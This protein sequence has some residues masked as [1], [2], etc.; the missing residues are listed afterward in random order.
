M[1]LGVYSLEKN[2]Y[3]DEARSVNCKTTMGEITI[4][5]N[6]QPLISV[7]AKGVIK[8]IDEQN[9]EHYIDAE[10]GFLT[11]LE[12]NNVRILIDSN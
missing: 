12:G 8:I 5:N 11:V 6:H 10:S 2:F 1:H 9:K 7:L 4:L 3:H